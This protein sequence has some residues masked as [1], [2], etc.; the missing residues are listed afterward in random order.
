MRAVAKLQ[1]GAPRRAAVELQVVQSVTGHDIQLYMEDDGWNL[2][3]FHSKSLVLND[4]RKD[5][6]DSLQCNSAVDYIHI[7]PANFLNY[8]RMIKINDFGLL[9][10]F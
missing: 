6:A 2:E 3:C 10:S 5:G 9:S 4:L 8:E 1:N 7:Q